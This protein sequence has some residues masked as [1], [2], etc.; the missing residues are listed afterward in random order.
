MYGNK[1]PS[2]LRDFPILGKSLMPVAL[3]RFEWRAD[4]GCGQ[5]KSHRQVAFPRR[6]K[7]DLNQKL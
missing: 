3:P 5:E 1:A 7:T 4:S 6:L 2:F